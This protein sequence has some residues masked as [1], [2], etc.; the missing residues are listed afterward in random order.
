MLDG[1]HSQPAAI[2]ERRP[3]LGFLDKVSEEMR[4]RVV[5]SFNASFRD[6]ATVVCLE[7]SIREP[8]VFRAYCCYSHP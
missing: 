1:V 3:S 8:V 7:D 6:D 2:D 4:F 5:Q